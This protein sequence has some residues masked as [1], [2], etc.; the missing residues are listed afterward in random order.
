MPRG[1]LLSR[2]HQQGNLLVVTLDL[3]FHPDS[4]DVLADLGPQLLQ[5][6]GVAID[7]QIDQQCVARGDPQLFAALFFKLGRK[8]R[9]QGSEIIDFLLRPLLARLTA[10]I[11]GQLFESALL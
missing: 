5:R 1:R 7:L 3:E 2:L 11:S 10:D 8:T 9:I 6:V 4:P